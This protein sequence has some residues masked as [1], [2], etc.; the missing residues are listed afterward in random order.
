MKYRFGINITYN[1]ETL[2]DDRIEIKISKETAFI[3]VDGINICSIYPKYFTETEL[4]DEIKEWIND[5]IEN[6]IYKPTDDAIIQAAK[7][8]KSKIGGN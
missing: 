5:Y 7:W 1:G 6:W 8:V 3:F 2:I 4:A